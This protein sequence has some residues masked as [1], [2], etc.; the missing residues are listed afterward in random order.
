MATITKEISD[1]GPISAY[2]TARSTV[3]GTPLSPDELDKIDAYWRASLY[4]CLGM[5][6]LKDNPLLREPL[7]TGAHQ[8][9]TVGPLGLGRRPGLHLHSLQPADQQVRSECDLHL[10]ARP[11]RAGCAI[12]SLSRGNIFRDLPRQERRLGGDA[13][14][15]QAVFF[16]GGIGSHCDSGNSR[17]HPRGRRAGLQHL[18]RL[19]DR[20]RQPGS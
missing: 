7:K 9:S 5:L 14:L 15:L 10:R 18:A 3:K 4:L 1:N 12:P 2:G 17:Q 8:A 6:Y 13:A 11:R 20:L 19:R 16:P